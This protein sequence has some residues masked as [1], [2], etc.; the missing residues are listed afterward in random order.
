[1]PLTPT[2]A[3]KETGNS[4]S[5][6]PIYI[7]VIAGVG[8]CCAVCFFLF[9]GAIKR[10]ESESEEEDEGVNKTS[11]DVVEELSPSVVSPRGFDVEAGAATTVPPVPPTR[12]V[13][14]AGAADSDEEIIRTIPAPA[15]LQAR[16]QGPAKI[17][18]K[19]QT[20]NRRNLAGD[21]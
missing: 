3:P 11:K 16:P 9:L 12:V 14:G 15:P 7:A 2:I 5:D 6:I 18:W 8:A 21:I 19:V 17:K 1:M 4:G 20:A 13:Y 10:E